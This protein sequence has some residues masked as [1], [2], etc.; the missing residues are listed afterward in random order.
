MLKNSEELNN[1]M[2][3][4]EHL[5][6][7]R[8]TL[9]RSCIA[10]AIGLILVFCFMKDVAGF[11]QMPL[12]KAY[13]SADLVDQNLITYRP[14]G[15]ISVYIQVAVLGGLSLA[16]PFILYFLACFIAP[17]LTDSERKILAPSCFGALL[18]FILGVLFAFW[19]V[20]PLTL[21][22]TVRL[23]EM[24]GFDLL[25]AASDYYNLVVWFSL[26]SG[27]FFQFPLVILV[28]IFL[29]IIPIHVLKRSRAT[30]LVA[31]MIFSALISPGGDFLSLPITT[32]MLYLL[33]ELS[34]LIGCKMV[35]RRS[36]AEMESMD[37]L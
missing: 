27:V 18:M 28:L 37:D 34:I 24:L 7:F 17:G 36:K 8:W 26:A 13:G 33:Y 19:I 5:E 4:L 14:M 32:A 2:T 6:E 29:D 11:L 30:V 21:G 10:F 16:M 23:N 3:F 15:V 31:L 12:L 25:W 20:L 35:K 22:F 1:E 9:G